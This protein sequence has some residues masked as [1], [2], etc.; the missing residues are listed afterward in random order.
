MSELNDL[1]QPVGL[2]VTTA[3]PRPRPPH[4]VLEG[5]YGRLVPLREI[6]AEGLYEAFSEDPEGRGWTYMPNGPWQ[7]V[8]QAQAW[9]RTGQ[10]SADPM[11]WCIQEPEGTPLGFC[12]VLRIAPEVGSIEVGFIHF[13]PRLQRTRL[14]TEVMYLL[15]RFAFD[16]LGYRRYE[17]KC[18]ALNAPSRQAAHRLGFTFE[19][20]FRQATVTKGRNRDTAWFSILDHEWPA[21]RE[22]FE[23]WLDPANF[24]GDANQRR[25][26]G[27]LAKAAL[28]V[29]S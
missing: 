18:D 1:G 5:R 29:R 3:L 28:P 13:A 9:C 24:D 25:S 17:W 12:S 19:G 2:P 8:T 7:S 14:A 16:D 26:L 22:A 27:E 15:M 21:L 6:H 20:V 4:V 10:A 11:F 23:T